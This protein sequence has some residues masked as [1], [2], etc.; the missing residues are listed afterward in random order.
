MIVLSARETLVK[1]RIIIGRTAKI[2]IPSEGIAGVIAKIDTGAD[3]SSI[4]ASELDVNEG[5]VLSFCLFAKDSEHYTGK[6]HETR[7]YTVS[8]VRSA[9]GTLQIR[10]KVQMVVRL[11]GRRVRGT[12]TLADRSRNTYPVLIGCRLLNKKFL[13]DVARGSRVVSRKKK[14]GIEEEFRKDPHAFFEKYH[15]NNHRGDI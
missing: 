7:S 3:N 11:G 8:A 15:R 13:V 6:R 12:F 2:S 10:Y 5:N 14:L 9:H 4:W 1:D